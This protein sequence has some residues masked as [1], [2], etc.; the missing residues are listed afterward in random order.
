MFLWYGGLNTG[1]SHWAISPTILGD[2]L[3]LVFCFKT[4]SCW[5]LHFLIV[6]VHLDIYNRHIH[7]WEFV[8]VN[9]II[10]FFFFPN[11]CHSL[12]PSFPPYLQKLYFYFSILFSFSFSLSSF[13]P[14]P[15]PGSPSHLNSFLLFHV[16]VVWFGPYLH[17]WFLKPEIQCDI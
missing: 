16:P 17:F 10:W 6:L 1:S 8:P 7:H 9:N 2:F 11:L 5:F 12:P 3:V 4:R 13:S 15:L 14:L